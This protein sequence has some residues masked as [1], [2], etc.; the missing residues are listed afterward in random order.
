MSVV[1][2]SDKQAGRTLP[3]EEGRGGHDSPFC[4]G[5]TKG[6]REEPSR[7]REHFQGVWAK[8]MQPSRWGWERKGS[9]GGGEVTARGGGKAYV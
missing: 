1:R 6:A 4:I 2:E 5:I 9:E 8:L 7:L 3:C